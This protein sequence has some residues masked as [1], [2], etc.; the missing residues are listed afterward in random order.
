MSKFILI[1]HSIV[2]VGGHYYEYAVRVLRAA[3]AAGYEPLLATNQRLRDVERLPWRVVPIYQYDFFEPKPPRML[4]DIAR[5]LTS[6][7]RRAARLKYRFL[8]SPLVLLL[9]KRLPRP[10]KLA[11]HRFPVTAVAAS[12]L[13]YLVRGYL[14]VA[15]FIPA[16]RPMAH[17]VRR[18]FSV[19]RHLWRPFS[20]RRHVPTQQIHG[21]FKRM[22]FAIDSRRLFRQV[23]L[24]RG[25]I[26]FIPT[27]TEAD[28]L[29]LLAMFKSN[30]NTAKATWHL[31]FR[32]NI[33]LGREPNYAAQDAA[34]ASRKKAFRR[35][36]SRLCGQRVFFY[37]DTEPLTAQYNRLGVA[38][39]RTAPIP[40]AADYRAP[41]HGLP[42]PS[43]LSLDGLG[44]PSSPAPA[45][46]GNR[47]LHVVY[48]GDARTE[49]GYHWLP[50]LVSDAF[51]ARLPVRF[52][53]QSN[54]N[55][56]GG[57]P[58][59]AVARAQLEALA[60]KGTGTF[61]AKHPSGGS[62]KMY[63]SP[64]LL[65]EACR[66][67][68][69]KHP[70]ASEEYRRLLLDAD[71][72]IVPY[73]RDNYYARSSGVFA[74]AL[75]AG[76]PVIVP[77]GTW[78]AGELPAFGVGAV[79]AERRDLLPSLAEVVN[80]YPHY[81][82]TAAAFSRAWSRYHCAQRLLEE[83]EVG[84]PDREGGSGHELPHSEG[85]CPLRGG[86]TNDV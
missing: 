26:V 74:E 73:D 64:F 53:F 20:G 45:I 11:K 25:D 14:V 57:E 10:K 68:L 31:L 66:V 30:P 12:V 44:R 42:W 59:V 1:D 82:S 63:L 84:L 70:L 19:A 60:E 6:V 28:M 77:R 27:L 37:T 18:F 41:E 83:I 16:V 85:C 4:G 38:L 24:D 61:C 51:A 79:Y 55:V 86:L 46:D 23:Q 49:K 8:F 62:G 17:A 36:Q 76:K 56:R 7:R 40:V 50:H 80:H 3:E 43:R 39:F 21:L 34:Q 29:G 32:R 13:V 81:R 71:V 47:L 78:M 65:P 9:I 69:I 2:D 72:V 52:T 22:A 67:N 33:Y 5:S 75:V 15:R 58:A 35:F 54:F 48:I